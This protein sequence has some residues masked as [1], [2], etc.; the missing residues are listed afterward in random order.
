MEQKR[1]GVFG[2][3]FHPIH[4]GHLLLAKH[5]KERLQ[6]DTVLFVIDRVP[7]HKEITDGATTEQR[8][9]LLRLALDGQD[10]LVPETMELSREGKSYSFDTLTELKQRYPNDRLFFLMGSDMLRAFDGW[11]RP[12]GISRLATLVC[13]ERFGQSGSEEET[14]AFLRKK[15]GA[16]ILLLRHK[17]GPR[18]SHNRA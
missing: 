15:Y 2:G 18:A 11:Y 3:T 4:N 6:L 7:P 9:R 8:L 5:A 10:G 13:T 14:A 1:I 16:E 17:V 12:D